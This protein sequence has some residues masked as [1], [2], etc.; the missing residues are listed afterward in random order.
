MGCDTTCR[1]LQVQ[2]GDPKVEQEIERKVKEFTTWFEKNPGRT[3]QVRGGPQAALPAAKLRPWLS[4]PSACPRASLEPGHGVFTESP[5]PLPSRQIC[6]S[7][8]ETRSHTGWFGS[9]QQQLDWEQWYIN[10]RSREQ[11]TASL[12]DSAQK[13]RVEAAVQ[14][15]IL[16]I[17]G[18]VNNRRDSIP[19]LVSGSVLTYPFK[20]TILG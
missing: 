14:D 11:E 9:Q 16:A 19:P 2:C 18:A 12:A 3:G 5:S 4:R 20:I 1:R 6:L 15:C 7:F 13:R 17:I 8:Y 10:L